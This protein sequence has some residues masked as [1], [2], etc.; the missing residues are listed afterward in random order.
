MIDITRMTDR[1]RDVVRIAEKQARLRG[2]TTVL[3][4]H[5]LL[6][7]AVEGAGVAAHVLKYVG[8]DEQTLSRLLPTLHPEPLEKMSP[9]D[10]DNEVVQ[11]VQRA[12]DEVKRLQHQYI[13]TEHLILGIVLSENTAVLAILSKLNVTPE[14]I[15]NEVYNLLGHGDYPKSE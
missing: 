15:C 10:W 5:V 12:M 3:P 14:V 1:S 6:A 11:A 8:G 2:C 7:L 9:I 13:G 4:E